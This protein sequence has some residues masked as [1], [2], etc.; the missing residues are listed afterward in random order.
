M[1][2]KLDSV[3]QLVVVEGGDRRQRTA[4]ASDKLVLESVHHYFDLKTNHTT[5]VSL[6]G[7]Q[8]NTGRRWLMVETDKQVSMHFNGS[9]AGTT[10]TLFGGGH[11]L[12]GVSNV[13]QLWLKND[14]TDADD[15][16][17]V[18]LTMH[19]VTAT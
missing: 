7:L 5:E 16:A 14:S 19:L 17:K 1:S 15:T 9:G 4:T 11:Y 2:Y 3:A 8:T 10:Q 12:G 18:V 13:T 6:G